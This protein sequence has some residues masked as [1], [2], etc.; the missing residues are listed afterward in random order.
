MRRTIRLTE[1]DLSR[2]VRRAIHEMDDQSEMGG[3][4]S[5]KSAMDTV[6]EFLESNGGGLGSRNNDDIE[7]DLQA[8]E[9]AIRIERNQLGVSNQSAGYK[10][11]SNNED[12]GMGDE[13]LSERYNK[14]RRN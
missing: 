9:Y 7:K 2:L 11:R 14:R 1:R 3:N 6:S 10:N 13:Q 12:G 8:L 4:S 5:T